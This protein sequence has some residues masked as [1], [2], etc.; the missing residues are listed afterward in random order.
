M[1]IELADAADRGRKGRSVSGAVGLQ[2]D[3]GGLVRDVRDAGLA[4]RFQHFGGNSRDGEWR[5][6]QVLPAE[7]G[8]DDDLFQAATRGLGLRIL[9]L[10]HSG[11]PQHEQQNERFLIHIAP[12]SSSGRRLRSRC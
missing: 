8:S 4:A 7:L 2:G 10:G 12:L 9:S 1:E 11:Q 5:F 6:L 3:V